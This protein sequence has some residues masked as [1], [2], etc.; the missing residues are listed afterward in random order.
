ML[1]LDLP[2]FTRRNDRPEIARSELVIPRERRK[3]CVLF[4]QPRALQLR[5]DLFSAARDVARGVVTELL[6]DGVHSAQIAS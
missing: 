2:P 5:S 4:G 3:Q 1:C 6:V